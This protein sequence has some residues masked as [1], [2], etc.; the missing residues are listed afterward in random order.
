MTPRKFQQIVMYFAVVISASYSADAAELIVKTSCDVAG[1]LVT[2][3]D[4]AEVRASSASEGEALRSARLFPAPSP[5]AVRWLRVREL[6][7][8]LAL[9][10]IELASL[11]IRG[12]ARVEIRR[13]GEQP[14]VGDAPQAAATGSDEQYL[15]AR[16]DLLKGDVLR[17]VDLEFRSAGDAGLKPVAPVTSLEDAIGQQLLRAVPAGQPLDYA[18]LR[19]PNL[20]ERGRTVGV[21]VRVGGIRVT[22]TGRALQ[23]GALDDLV[24]VELADGQRKRVIGRV[25]DV[26]EVEILPQGISIDRTP[27]RSAM[28]G[29]SQ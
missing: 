1:P 29:G 2:L 22:T 28:R 15:V 9:Q 7:E 13:A 17:A 19:R 23:A 6:Q 11:R 26:D 12:A 21:V 18:F 27:A 16:R 3:G 5:G 20:V 8:L 24:T 4:V 25:V 14:M 10:G